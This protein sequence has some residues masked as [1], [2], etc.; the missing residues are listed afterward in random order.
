MD[1]DTNL[2][3]RARR[4]ASRIGG[5]A[6]AAALLAA[7]GGE[8][9]QPSGRPMGAPARAKASGEN[10][11][12]RIQHV[13]LDPREPHA[14]DDVVARVQ[15]QDADGD[16][17]ELQYVWTLDGRRVN[18]R[19]ASLRVPDGTRKGVPIAVEVVA[20]D[21]RQGSEPARAETRIGNRPPALLGVH[22][23][24]YQGAKVGSEL[25]AVAQARDADDDRIEFSYAWR[26]NGRPT[27]ATGERFSTAELKRG[28]VVQVRVVASDGTADTPPLDSAPLTLGNAAPAITSTPGGVS[29]DGGFAYAVQVS[30]PDGD[31]N[32]RF[33]LEQ[34]PEGARVDPVLGEVTWLAGRE[35]VGR[36]AFEVVVEDGHGGEARQRF[37]VDVREVPRDIAATDADTPPASL[38]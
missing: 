9:P 8:T 31:R 22:V 6:A 32:L 33:R 36:H 19:G 17:I 4:L 21:G 12:P 20:H 29:A 10:A 18:E 24:P 7:C 2:R 30:D 13:A 35:H 27:A 28:D 26:V 15:A 16:P 5:C 23:E 14:G 38:E 34:G 25:V 3:R 37:E 11:A 1:P